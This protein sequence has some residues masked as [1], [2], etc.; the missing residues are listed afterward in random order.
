M[1]A[2]DEIKSV[3]SSKTDVVTVKKTSDTGLQITAK[4]KVDSATVAVFMRSGARAKVR[5]HVQKSTVAVTSVSV[6]TSKVTLR[7]GGD[8]KKTTHT[9][10]V[11][12]KPVTATSSIRYSS[13]NTNVAI[14]N[15]TTGKIRAKKAGTA[16]VTVKSGSKSKKITVTVKNK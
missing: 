7:L 6:D 10:A 11:T 4:N 9:I 2:T 8:N 5:L 1:I 12:L 15:R 16:T 14:V 13:S 3:R